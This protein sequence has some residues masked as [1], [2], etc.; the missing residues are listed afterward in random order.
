MPRGVDA[1]R[2]SLL[3]GVRQLGSEAANRNCHCEAKSFKGIVNIF[4]NTL[5]QSHSIK[6]KFE[7]LLSLPNCN[8]SSL[9]G[10]ESS[11]SSV[12][13]YECERG[14]DRHKTIDRATECAMTSVGK[15]DKST[16]TRKDLSVLVTSP[17]IHVF[18]TTK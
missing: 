18:F 6:R 15:M 16:L 9:R 8:I 7:N 5:S 12:T 11:R 14:V 17:N 4:E 1:K 2:L 10:R 13:S 3:R